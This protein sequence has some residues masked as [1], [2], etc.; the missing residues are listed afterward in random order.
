MFDLRPLYPFDSTE[1]QIPEGN[2]SVYGPANS[3]ANCVPASFTAALALAGY[4][5]VDPQLV[6]NEIYGPNY[7]G[8]FGD[9]TRMIAW[10]RSHVANAPAC[11]DGGFD[12]NVAEAAGQAGKLIVVAGWIVPS[13]VTFAAQS[14][15]GGF[16]H[17]SILAAHL[18]GDKYVIWNTWFGQFQTYDKA[19]LA[20]SLYEM[21]VMETARFG[22]LTG[23]L[24]M[25]TQAQIDWVM[26]TLAQMYY[27]KNPDGSDGSPPWLKARLDKLDSEAILAGS[28]TAALTAA[29]LQTIQET[30]DAVTKLAAT[31]VPIDPAQLTGIAADLGAV[32]M[33]IEKDLAS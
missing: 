22:A 32:R 10:V 12:F 20:A 1:G 3:H 29:E 26:A 4:P 19:V 14:V 8:G 33:R 27:G 5:D 6:T 9:F 2:V 28:K 7:R 15:S 31:G 11:S 13:S 30:H 16:S 17:A 21:S 24:E 23:E 18:A 25:W